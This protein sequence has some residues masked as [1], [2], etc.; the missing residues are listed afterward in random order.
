[1]RL[2]QRFRAV[3]LVEVGCQSMTSPAFS[4]EKEIGYG[5]HMSGFAHLELE[6]A[7]TVLPK[8]KSPCAHVLDVEA[9]GNDFEMSMRRCEPD[10]CRFVGQGIVSGSHYRND[11]LVGEGWQ[12]ESR[13]APFLVQT[14]ILS[15]TLIATN[16]MNVPGFFDQETEKEFFL[17]QRPYVV[18]AI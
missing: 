16:C 13:C 9:C 14:Q 11:V 18:F 10:P 2:G 6:G 5:N 1:M 17:G 7:A 12:S 15:M 3:G 4:Q 8:K